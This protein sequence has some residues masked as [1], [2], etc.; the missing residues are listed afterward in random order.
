MDLYIGQITVFGFNFQP[1]GWLQCNGQTLSIASYQNLY[2]LIGTKFGGNGTT[3]FNLP[4]LNASI[5]F[6][7]AK[8]YIATEGIYPSHS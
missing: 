4:N 7:T 8:Y 2:T 6:N 1:S 3:T 5:F